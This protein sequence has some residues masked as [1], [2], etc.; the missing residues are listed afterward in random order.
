LFTL[1]PH[2]VPA[3]PRK[4]DN[5]SEMPESVLGEAKKRGEEMTNIISFSESLKL[6]SRYDADLLLLK[7]LNNFDVKVIKFSTR[8]ALE[9]FNKKAKLEAVICTQVP[10][11]CA[12]YRHQTDSEGSHD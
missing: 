8:K 3:Q 9:S 5:V 12:I 4:A 7:P 6:R 11:N 2:L 10:L 1:R